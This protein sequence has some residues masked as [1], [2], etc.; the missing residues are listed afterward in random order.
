M[1]IR[2]HMTPDIGGIG[3]KVEREK[4]QT[5]AIFRP[6]PHNKDIVRGPDGK[7]ETLMPENEIANG[8]IPFGIATEDFEIVIAANGNMWAVAKAR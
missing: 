7:L 8:M 5:P 1:S 2:D 4:P 6:L 3:K